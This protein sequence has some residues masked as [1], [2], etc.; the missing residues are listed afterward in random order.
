M[1]EA[2]KSGTR[3]K[4]VCVGINKYPTAPLNGCVADAELWAQTL[5]N[6]DF[7][8]RILTDDQATREG[9][10]NALEAL[11]AGGQPGDVLVFQFAGHGTQVKDLDGDEDDD[12]DEAL[13]PVD[14]AEGRFVID[15]DIWAVLGK[16][17]AGVNLTVFLDCCHSG[18]ATRAFGFPFGGSPATTDRRRYLVASREMRDAHMKFRE[19]LGTTG[20]ECSAEV[21][22]WVNFSACQPHEV[23]WESK[24]QGDFTRHATKAL[25]T[26]PGGFTHDSFQACILDAF[27]ATP[28]QRP[29]LD[30]TAEA[31][32][33]VLLAPVT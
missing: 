28:R 10:L 2:Y 4:A 21:M 9:I 8:T 18:S 16:L 24:G 11:V 25:E 19:D 1:S 29:Y 5:E 20:V 22:A 3:R 12:R 23:A 30:C 6:L 7:E 27:G 31:R 15:D 14:I 32:K 26:G 13:C 33:Q 17:T